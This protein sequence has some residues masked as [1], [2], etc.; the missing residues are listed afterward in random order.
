M[1][2]ATFRCQ[3][4]VAELRHLRAEAREAG[5]L[6]EDK[7][8]L[9]NKVRLKYCCCALQP[10]SPCLPSCSCVHLD[11]DVAALYVP[12]TCVRLPLP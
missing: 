2:C 9:E 11:V 8:A 1:S 10:R 4:A 6:L 3:Q 7:K 5:K 12:T